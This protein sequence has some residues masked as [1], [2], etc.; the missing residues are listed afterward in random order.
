M[1][2][3]TALPWVTAVLLSVACCATL[4]LLV[5][6]STPATTHLNDGLDLRVVNVDP[7][8][9]AKPST[10]GSGGSPTDIGESLARG[11]YEEATRERPL[12]PIMLS[13]ASDGADTLFGNDR[14]LSELIVLMCSAKFL[15]A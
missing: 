8:P 3:A 4:P 10:K 9:H 15:K 11:I 6:A 5:S 2:L 1:N 12:V 13:G 14:W 7:R